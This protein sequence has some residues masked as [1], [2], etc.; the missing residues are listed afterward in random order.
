MVAGVIEGEGPKEL[1]VA[2]KG[3]SE[4]SL[5]DGNVL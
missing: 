4:G 1:G 5:W 2:I 3:Q